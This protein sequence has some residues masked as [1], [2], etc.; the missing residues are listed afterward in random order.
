MIMLSILIFLVCSK[1]MLSKGHRLY[2]FQE[3]RLYDEILN[4]KIDLKA[5]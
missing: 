3:N 1:A 5:K 4:E 2:I